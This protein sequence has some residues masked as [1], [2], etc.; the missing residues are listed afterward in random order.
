MTF[1]DRPDAV[2]IIGGAGLFCLVNLIAFLAVRLDK[3]RAETN[4]WRIP[5]RT[6]IVWAAIGG[7][8]GA[9][10][11]QSRYRHKT[12]KEPF[13]SILN[14]IPFLWLIIGIAFWFEIWRWF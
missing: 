2:L 6:L 1:F 4:A 8:F 12:R 9:K 10:L 3:K 5:E 14:A 11:A 13:R 7:W